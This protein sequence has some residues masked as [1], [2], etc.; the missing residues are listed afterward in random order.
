MRKVFPGRYTARTEGSFVVF[1]IGMRIN[2]IV[3]VRKWVQ[4]ARAMPPMLRELHMQSEFGFLGMEVFFHWRGVV[5]L[6]YWK[7]FDHLHSYAHG[8]RHLPAWTAYNRA[9]GNDGTV[10]V[11]HETYLVEPKHSESV[12]A[13]MP[14]WGLG[15]AAEHIPI[16]G[17]RDSARQRIEASPEA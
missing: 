6:Q 13:N 11:W 4:V 17:V 14:R 10:G 5:T 1:L 2:R 8:A 12:Y 7:S 15:K 3:A 16:T 9:I